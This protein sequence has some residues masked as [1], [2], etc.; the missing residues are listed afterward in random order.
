MA[1]KDLEEI[2]DIKTIKDI[3][4]VFYINLKHRTDRKKHVE[5]QLTS[6]GL[7]NFERFD[8]NY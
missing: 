3:K 7:T 5:E 8:A 2:K 6:I 1:S 4:N